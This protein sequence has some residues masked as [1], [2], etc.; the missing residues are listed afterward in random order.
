MNARRGRDDAD[1]C[2]VCGP[3][4]PIGLKL[5]FRLEED[6]CHGEFTPGENHCGFDG[7]THGGIIFSALDDVMANW[8]FLKGIRGYTAKCDIRFKEP[9]PVGCPVALESR[10]VKQRGKL[11]QMEGK[12]AR[13][14]NRAVIAECLGTFM[15]DA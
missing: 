10:C 8:L 11:V 13:V 6:R 5:S 4:N 9:L 2:F 12:A 15:V 7:I 14:D 1:S 3:K